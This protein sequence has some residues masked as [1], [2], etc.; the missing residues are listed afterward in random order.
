MTNFKRLQNPNN[1][2]S[3]IDTYTARK[4]MKLAFD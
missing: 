1:L 2:K 4:L 3:E